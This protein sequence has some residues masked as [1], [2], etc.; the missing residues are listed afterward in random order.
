VPF[1]KAAHNRELDM[2]IM[3]FGGTSIA[4][5]SRLQA[6]AKLIVAQQSSRRVV[7]V[8]S[9][10]SG[11]TDHLVA[12]ATAAAH[13]KQKQLASELKILYEL[14]MDTAS[15]LK[16]PKAA[17][18]N[19]RQIIDDRF[20]DLEQLLHSVYTLGELTPRALDAIL[21]FGE[22]LSVHLVAQSVRS[23]GQLAE[24]L[25]ASDFIVTTDQFG[26]AQ[27]LLDKSARLTKKV[28]LPLV[29][30]NIVP[31]ITGYI[32]ATGEGVIT[33][34]GRGGS[35]YS[36]TI[37]G[38]CL[39]AKEVW[40]WTD[41]NGVMT[42]DPRLVSEAHTISAL[43][44]N[45]AAELSYFGAKVLHPLTMLPVALKKIP[46][47]IK[48]T[49]NPQ[50][51]GTKISAATAKNGY[52]G[53]AISTLGGL[54]LITVQGK[55]MMG[56]PGVAAKVFGA[57][58]AQEVNVMFISQASSEYNI[59]FVVEHP[60]GPKAVR[61]L[62][63]AFQLELTTKTIETIKMEEKLAIVA[64]VGEGMRGQPGIAGKTFSALGAAGVNIRAI[65]QGSSE[66]NISFVVTSSDVP[67]AVR[68]IHKAFHLAN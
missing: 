51:E 40:I 20:L 63:E 41:V 12:A 1:I 46:I 10:L 36:A 35:D 34:L 29:N 2:I 38:Y 66:R 44:Y 49:F 13:K 53:H 18:D 68:S 5:A 30:K 16:L 6:V 7:V 23:Q 65:A 27:P 17:Q 54:S 39:G 11:V 50:L 62:Q 57:I 8:V 22:R 3:K 26:K 55:G 37:L 48:N 32:G 42:A 19:L 21:S 31:I 67:R 25:E 61:I 60:E 43:S 9:A 52:S 58:A 24:A 45:E 15:K 56:V 59:S 33:T 64:I 4:S 47:L 14:H 28:L